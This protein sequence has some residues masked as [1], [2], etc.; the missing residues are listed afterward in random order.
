M[1]GIVRMHDS[2]ELE[3]DGILCIILI[4]TKYDGSLDET[5]SVPDT[6]TLDK[7]LEFFLQIC[8]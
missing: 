3:C 8:R 5:T 4:Q 1:D 2:F 6:G 7:L